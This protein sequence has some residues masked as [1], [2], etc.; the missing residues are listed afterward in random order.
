MLL[1]EA[2]PEIMFL[3]GDLFLKNLI[4]IIYLE[5]AMAP[6]SSTLAWRIPWTEEPGRLQAMGSLRVG[7]DWATSLSLFTFM[8]W[9][10]KWQF[11]MVFQILSSCR[12]LQDAEYSSLC[13]T[14]GPCCYC[15]VYSRVYL[16]IPGSWF[17][18]LPLAPLIVVSVF[19]V[20][21]SNRWAFGERLEH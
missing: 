8:H 17:V 13:C 18:L 5:K 1:W 11:P 15:F 7:H 4:L 19:S 16:R 2:Q 20:S 3:T 6:H 21:A 12:L 10:R 9:R 14:A